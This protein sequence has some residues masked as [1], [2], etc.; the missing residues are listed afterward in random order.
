[1]PIAWLVLKKGDYRNRQAGYIAACAMLM[2][3][4]TWKVLDWVR[5]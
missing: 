3:A 4:A 1:M 2:G 5:V